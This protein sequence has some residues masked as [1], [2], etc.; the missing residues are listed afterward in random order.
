MPSSAAP[1][2]ASPV[3]GVVDVNDLHLEDQ[4]AV[5]IGDLD[6]GSGEHRNQVAAGGSAGARQTV[7]GGALGGGV[8]GTG[9]TRVKHLTVTEVGSQAQRGP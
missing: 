4:P 5:G 2:R 3:L 1:E 9:W 6:G 7:V 8:V